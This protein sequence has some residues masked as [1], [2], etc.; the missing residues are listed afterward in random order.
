MRTRLN[1][2]AR[3]HAD[4]LATAMAKQLLTAPLCFKTSSPGSMEN[5]SVLHGE[6]ASAHQANPAKEQP[7]QRSQLPE[8]TNYPSSPKPSGMIL[9]FE[10][11]K[12]GPM[13]SNYLEQQPDVQ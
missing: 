8:C 5:C 10:H 13:A 3:T 11:P 6:P 7:P 9:Q 12:A 4:P 1:V 2:Y